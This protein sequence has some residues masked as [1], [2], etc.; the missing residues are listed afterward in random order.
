M[1][2]NLLALVLLGLVGMCLAGAKKNPQ[3][4]LINIVLEVTKPLQHERGDR[5]PLY[6]WACHDVGTGEPAEAEKI[7]KALNER[8]IAVIST[9]NPRPKNRLS[10]LKRALM[11]AKIQTKLGLRVNVNANACM[12]SFF[13]G[14]ERTAHITEDG[15]KFFDTSHAS[16]RK[17]GCPF[18]V[19][20]RYDEIRKRF[21]Y[22]AK[23]YR[24]A[25]LRVDFV[26]LD[27]EIDGPIE[28]NDA[29]SY[30]RKCVRCRKHIKNIDDFAAFQ[31]AYR[32]IRARMQRE[33]YSKVFKKY[34]PG[35]LVGNY[36]VYPHDGYRY[37]YDYYERFTDGA[38]Y[39]SDQRA[40]YR[41]WFH[42]FPFTGY[43]FA[44][45]VVYTWYDTFR[46]YDYKNPDYRWF[47][48]ML[49]VA[50]NACKS[51]KPKIPIIPFVH[52]HTTSPPKEPDPNV[53]QFSASAY[54]EL[55]WHILLRGVDTFFLW[56]PRKETETEVPLVHQVYAESLAY[57]EFLDRGKPITFDVPKEQGP[58]VSGLRL[59]ERVL[60][61]RT[62]FDDTT[63]PVKTKVGRKTLLIPRRDSEC[64]ILTLD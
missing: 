29:W 57:K 49:L 37:W 46:W 51:T 2:G 14:D 59:G 42:E 6:L 3:L 15:E 27:W 16:Y 47:Y 61:R 55:L 56:S 12:Y 24:D 45:P 28:W 62:D 39:L 31:R 63:E 41:P 17:I 36:G 20:F 11:V 25:G 43:T 8:G 19:E 48:N 10:S 58:V 54:K 40:K 9:W 7:I 32:K 64:Q 4:E 52:W 1:R 44:M 60:I 38:P 33:C 34:F 23:A 5:L 21:E 53:K 35:V 50:T 18:S 22:F 30:A 26:F 13:N